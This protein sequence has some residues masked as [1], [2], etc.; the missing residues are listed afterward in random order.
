MLNMVHEVFC[1]SSALSFPKLCLLNSTG[2]NGH[3]CRKKSLT[4]PFINTALLAASYNDLMTS[5]SRLWML[6]SFKSRQRRE[7]FGTSA[8]I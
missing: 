4:L 7:D 5:V 8:A 3:P 2:D 1:N 6:Y